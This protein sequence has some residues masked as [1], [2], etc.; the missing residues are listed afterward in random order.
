[1]E[2]STMRKKGWKLVM[3]AGPLV[4]LFLVATGL[5]AFAFLG[6]GDSARW[7][8]EVL[9]HDGSKIVVDRSQTRGGQGEIGQSP[10]KEHSMT[11]TLPGT[12][13]VITWKDEYSQDVGHSNFDLLALHIKNSTPYIV[14]SSYGCLAYNKWGRPNPPHVYFR[15]DGNTWQRIPL[16]ELPSEFKNINLVINASA[17]QEKLVKKGIAPAE[18]IR[19]LNSSLEKDPEYSTILRTPLEKVEEGCPE[20]ISYKCNG[21]HVGWAAPGEFNKDFFEKTCKSRELKN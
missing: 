7:K 3:R 15:F 16:Q 19:K 13:K 8:E 9:L 12:K 20:L 6:F 1:M 5:N 18:M 4:L 10:I 11:F 2:V 14:V 17:H 21:V